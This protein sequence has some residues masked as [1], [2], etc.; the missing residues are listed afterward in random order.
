MIYLLWCNNKCILWWLTM[1]RTVKQHLQCVHVQPTDW[2]IDNMCKLTTHNDSFARSSNT[3]TPRTI[4]ASS[5]FGSFANQFTLLPCAIS[6]AA[7]SSASCSVVVVVL[8]LLI[9]M[10]LV[11]VLLLPIIIYLLIQYNRK[12]HSNPGSCNTILYNSIV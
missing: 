12:Q 11:A 9:R 6:M 8:T 7:S 4:F 2:Q 3:S 1:C 10:L 5:S